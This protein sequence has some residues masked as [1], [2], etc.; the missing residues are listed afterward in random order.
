MDGRNQGASFPFP[1]SHLGLLT[2]HVPQFHFRMMTIH[3]IP[4]APVTNGLLRTP[5]VAGEAHFT[6]VQPHRA[7]FNDPDVGDRTHLGTDAAAGTPRPGE[8]ESHAQPSITTMSLTEPFIDTELPCSRIV[9][10]GRAENGSRAGRR[11]TGGEPPASP[12]RSRSRPAGYRPPCPACCTRS[13][14]TTRVGL[15]PSARTK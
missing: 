10:R 3:P 7:L 12:R 13:S 5:L 8:K 14:F 11:R 6:A 15:K 9:R 4:P 2:H 1:L